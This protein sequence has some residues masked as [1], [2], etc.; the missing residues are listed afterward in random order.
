MLEIKLS[1]GSKI[2]GRTVEEL[3]ENLT[4]AYDKVNE[5]INKHKERLKNLITKRNEIRRIIG[6]KASQKVEKEP[7]EAEKPPEG[8]QTLR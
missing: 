8:I 7:K 4:K 3:E 6:R 5:E 1:D 2:R